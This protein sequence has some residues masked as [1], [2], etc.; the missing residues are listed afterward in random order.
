MA[1]LVE[2]IEYAYTEPFKGE[3]EVLCFLRDKTYPVHDMY[4]DGYLLENEQGEGHIV[5]RIGD[6]WFDDHFRVIG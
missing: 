3:P 4:E 1:Q 6:S 2:C 5:G